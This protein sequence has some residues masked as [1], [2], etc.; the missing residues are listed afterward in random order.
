[1]GGACTKQF[2]LVKV[3]ITA[4]V[5]TTRRIVIDKL[6]VMDGNKLVT[7]AV[8]REVVEHVKPAQMIHEEM[9]KSWN[10]PHSERAR[11]FTERAMFNRVLLAVIPHLDK[12]GWERCETVADKYMLGPIS[13]THLSL[14]FTK[15][16]FIEKA[17][18]VQAWMAANDLLQINHPI[19]FT[20]ESKDIVFESGT[21]ITGRPASVLIL[22]RPRSRRGWHALLRDHTYTAHKMWEDPD[23]YSLYNANSFRTASDY[24]RAKDLKAV[25]PLNSWVTLVDTAFLLHRGWNSI[26]AVR[27][28]CQGL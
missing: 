12:K 22:L 28:R 3:G 1:M 13:E 10:L 27:R 7:P 5:K 24:V 2:V 15:Q 14:A 18:E 9:K 4:A 17:E 26:A 23:I 11:T 16:E 8:E 25:V 6:K 21:V 20:T 19:V